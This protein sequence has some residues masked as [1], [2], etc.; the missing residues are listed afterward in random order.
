MRGGGDSE[1]ALGASAC[2]SLLSMASDAPRKRGDELI[3]DVV[4]FVE[5]VKRR[6]KSKALLDGAASIRLASSLFSEGDG[7]VLRV[8]K[9]VPPL[10]DS[11]PCGD[12]E[13]LAGGSFAPASSL[14]V[15]EGASGF[16]TVVGDNRALLSGAFDEDAGAEEKRAASDATRLPVD[17]L[18]AV[19]GGLD[20][21]TG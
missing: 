21:T 11:L 17:C 14:W 16:A 5:G 4:A 1:D 9:E 2:F 13:S 6:G 19:M 8:D 3:R 15:S 10:F 18:L 12:G 7:E 20:C